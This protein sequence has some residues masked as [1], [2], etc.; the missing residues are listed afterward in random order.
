MRQG[1]LVALGS[2]L[3]LKDKFGQGYRLQLVAP[4]GSVGAIK[5]KVAELLPAA[6]A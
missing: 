1:K 3:R 5:A 2:S 6:A 4:R